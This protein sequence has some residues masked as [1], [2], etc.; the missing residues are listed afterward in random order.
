MQFPKT[1]RLTERK[2]G[3]EK[4]LGLCWHGK[5]PH[6]ELCPS[7]DSKTRLDSLLHECAHAIWPEFDEPTIEKIAARMASLL[8]ADGWR[9][10]YK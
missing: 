2:L 4:A 9:R 8:W 7:Q 10:I 3:K 6:I 1:I 5:I